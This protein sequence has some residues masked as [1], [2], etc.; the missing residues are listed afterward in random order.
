MIVPDKA[1]V[2]VGNIAYLRFGEHTSLEAQNLQLV[3]NTSFGQ[4]PTHLTHN[5]VKIA[6]LHSMLL[7]QA[8]QLLFLSGRDAFFVSLS[9]SVAC[10]IRILSLGRVDALPQRR[11]NSSST[12]ALN[13]VFRRLDLSFFAGVLASHSPSA[14]SYKTLVEAD[15]DIMALTWA[16][17]A[18]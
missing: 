5:G 17:I 16:Y 11:G 6:L 3:G 15:H 8:S 4:T 14:E 1:S 12:Q 18:E 13:M 7:K 10:R 2:A 9:R